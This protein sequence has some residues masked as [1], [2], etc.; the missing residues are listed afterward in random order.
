MLEK[1]LGLE[2]LDI[3]EALNNRAELFSKQ[4]GILVL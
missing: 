2:H 4:V 1:A 3:A